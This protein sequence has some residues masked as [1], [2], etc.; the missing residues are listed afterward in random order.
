MTSPQR[1]TLSAAGQ[2]RDIAHITARPYGKYVNFTIGIASGVTE[3]EYSLIL[4]TYAS[5]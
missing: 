4:N 1:L 2:D 5:S 3:I